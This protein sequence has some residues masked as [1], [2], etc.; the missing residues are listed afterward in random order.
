MTPRIRNAG[1]TSAPWKLNDFPTD[2][3]YKIAR[4]IVAELHL[5]PQ[6]QLPGDVWEQIFARAAGV[7]WRNT[8]VGLADVQA[9]GCSWSAKT[10]ADDPFGATEVDLIS[11]RNNVGYSYKG[12]VYKRGN[13]DDAQPVGDRVLEIWNTRVHSVYKGTE[14]RTAVLIRHTDG[15]TY[16]LFEYE[17]SAYLSS[18][19]KWEWSDSQQLIGFLPDGSR[20][21]RWQPEGSQ[22]TIFQP[23]PDDLL[24][25]QVQRPRPLNREKVL[26]DLGYSEEWVKLLGKRSPNP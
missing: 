21:F 17:T 22:F 15:V 25:F 23:V 10:V 20:R 12:F 4:Q 5:N 1:K 18:L 9:P 13:T 2:F 16:G 3:P 8:R 24:I 26:E 11:G 19:V 14:L 7:P 6:S